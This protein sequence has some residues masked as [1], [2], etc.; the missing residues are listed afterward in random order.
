MDKDF[1]PVQKNLVEGAKTEDNSVFLVDLGGG[2]GHDLQEL[3]QKH[4]NIPGKLVLQ[5][6]KDVIDE[7][8]TTGLDSK[9]VPMP[10]DFFTSQPVIGKF[11]NTITV[12]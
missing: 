7:A 9:I 10:H 6:L 11:L 1:F 5:E 4:P 12:F 2:K 8:V 3:Y